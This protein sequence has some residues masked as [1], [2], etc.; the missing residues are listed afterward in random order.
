[1]AS[2]TAEREFLL[3]TFSVPYTKPMTLVWLWKM[4]KLHLGWFGTLSGTFEK[5]SKITFLDRS[6]PADQSQI[7]DI[8]KDEFLSP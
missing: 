6:G 1:M 4:S 2:F 3:G 5:S 8:L 7:F